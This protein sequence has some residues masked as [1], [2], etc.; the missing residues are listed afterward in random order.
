MNSKQTLTDLK[1]SCYVKHELL[2]EAKRQLLVCKRLSTKSFESLLTNGLL[3]NSWILPGVSGKS[4]RVRANCVLKLLTFPSKDLRNTK[5]SM[6]N[7]TQHC[8]INKHCIEHNKG[9]RAECVLK[10]LTLPC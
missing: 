3:Q 9:V 10:L 1:I 6:P 7:Q 5:L 4:K 2:K 8:H